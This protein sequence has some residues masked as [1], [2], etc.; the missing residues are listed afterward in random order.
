MYDYLK[1]LILKKPKKILLQIG[2]N[3][4]PF[5][6]ADDIIADMTNLKAWIKS[7][8][9]GCTVVFC[10]MPVRIDDANADSVRKSVNA[11]MDS[12]SDLPRIQNSNIGLRNLSAT[13]RCKGLHLNL[14]GTKQLAVNILSFLK[15]EF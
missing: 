4:C 3:D 1:P 11:L 6:Q 10:E 5:V 15:T 9:P 8:N 7:I 12:I 2:A 13:G 14:S